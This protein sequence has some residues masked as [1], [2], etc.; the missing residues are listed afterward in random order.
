MSRLAC[1]SLGHRS[2]MLLAVTMLLVSA[3]ATPSAPGLSTDPVAVGVEA[4]TEPDAPASSA[5]H[6]AAAGVDATVGA[7]T[8]AGGGAQA[9]ATGRVEAPVV[10]AS[11][12]AG[13]KATVSP[14][15]VSAAA[16][17]SATVKTPAVEAA[18]GLSVDAGAGAHPRGPRP[19]QPRDQPAD[20]STDRAAP[21]SGRPRPGRPSHTGPRVAPR[22]R[23]VLT[24]RQRAAAP[25][26][27]GPGRS[28]G[29]S[30]GSTVQTTVIGSAARSEGS[31]GRQKL[32]AVAVA[33][34]RG[35]TALL[36]IL[37]AFGAYVA[38]QRRLD[39]GPRMAWTGDPSRSPDDETLYF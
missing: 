30:T 18:A 33:A 26:R 17:A 14:S 11:A 23:S 10:G 5:A 34:A 25:S 27:S 19:S 38:V 15:G 4:A 8:A 16:Q 7:G 3:A 37:A 1:C 36:A 13:A 31:A 2:G 9:Q 35:L 21:S 39:R 6:V 20:P 12:E 24:R 28:A 32:R 29:P 22:S